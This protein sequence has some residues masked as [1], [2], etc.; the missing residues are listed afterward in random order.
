MLPELSEIKAKR[1]TLGL[2]QSQL[3]KKCNL[4]QSLVAKIESGQVSPSYFAVKAIFDFFNSLESQ[5]SLCA[6][7]IMTT[8]IASV[9]ASDSVAHAVE[10][11]RKFEISQVPVFEGSMAVGSFS[12]ENISRLIADSARPSDILKMKVSQAMSQPFASV[13]LKTPVLSIAYLLSHDKA[14]LIIDG[15]KVCGIVTK[16]DLLKTL[17]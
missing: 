13:S 11:L 12:E 1:K 8:K 7:D 5:S 15:K 9:S 16:A 3:A 17:R 4:S 14:V 10:S 2:T 6:R